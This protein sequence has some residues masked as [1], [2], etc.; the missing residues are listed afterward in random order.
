MKNLK[1]IT[2][3]NEI[4][5]IIKNYITN[6]KLSEEYL[7][8]FDCPV[9]IL[10]MLVNDSNVLVR[11]IGVQNKNC[12]VQTLERII[13]FDS[14]STI[15]KTAIQNPNCTT[16]LLDRLLMDSDFFIRDAAKKRLE[17]IDKEEITEFKK[18]KHEEELDNMILYY[19][20]LKEKKHQ[21]EK[22]NRPTTMADPTELAAARRMAKQN[23]GKLNID[24]NE[25]S[26][27]NYNNNISFTQNPDN[28]VQ[29][30]QNDDIQKS[31]DVLLNVDIE[32]DEDRL[33]E[34]EIEKELALEEENESPSKLLITINKLK[35]SNKLFVRKF[36]HSIKVDSNTFLTQVN[37]HFE[38]KSEFLS[39]LNFLNLENIDTTNLK[40]SGINISE[41]N[42]KIDP[43]LIYNKDLSNTTL[44]D[45][46]LISYNFDGVNMEGTNVGIKKY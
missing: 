41:S 30:S 10:T 4:A 33:F 20:E 14:N 23:V 9:D 13:K 43:Q 38:I 42:L 17:T 26:N 21:E 6:T 16:E 39:V 11:K 37:D 8:N 31:K 34:A 45:K 7:I 35:R 44:D 36:Y 28:L 2:D 25:I 27:E 22:Q 5:N 12:S 18:G 46:N 15:K 3:L 32:S 24:N 19:N 1:D 40:I 29:N